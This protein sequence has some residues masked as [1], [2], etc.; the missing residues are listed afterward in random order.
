MP[1]LFSLIFIYLFLLSTLLL[2]TIVW[3]VLKRLKTNY[4]R[5]NWK[6]RRRRFKREVEKYLTSPTAI[7]PRMKSSLKGN[8]RQWALNQLIKY[9]TKLTDEGVKRLSKL[10]DEWGITKDIEKGMSSK[11]WWKRYEALYLSAAFQVKKERPNVLKMCMDENPLIRMAAITTLSSIGEEDDIFEIFNVLEEYNTEYYQLDWV[12]HNLANIKSTNDNAFYER[13][14]LRY[15]NY[16]K[17]FT[18]RCILEWM[19]QKNRVDCI[20]F[21]LNVMKSESGE[22][23]VGAVKAL[24]S[25]EAK[26]ALPHFEQNINDD[27]ELPGI[28]ILSMKG[29]ALF[30]DEQFA[31]C[32]ENN[33]GHQ[34]W[35]VRYYSA[36]GLVKLGHGGEQELVRLEK[37]HPDKYARDMSRYYLDM[38]KLKGFDNYVHS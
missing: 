25:L 24:I 1:F 3:L 33:L 29:I 32:M 19:G 5:K 14:K 6:L 4:E 2:I 28:K 11:H 21:I 10:M 37:E 27:Y 36:F 26:I 23:K 9:E 8:F 15:P 34:L 7:T 12:L 18:R 38:L 13:V 22:V 31:K 20:P 30:G 16:K 35:W 17:A